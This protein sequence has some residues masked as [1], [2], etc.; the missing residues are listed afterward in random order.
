MDVLLST[1]TLGIVANAPRMNYMILACF[2]KTGALVEWRRRNLSTCL[3]TR[4]F[5]AKRLR[6]ALVKAPPAIA[7]I[8]Q[9]FGVGTTAKEL[10]KRI[11]SCSRRASTEGNVAVS[12]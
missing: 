4:G 8:S 10:K 5:L 3:E 9:F 2:H 11:T 12:M 1:L 7:G 6:L